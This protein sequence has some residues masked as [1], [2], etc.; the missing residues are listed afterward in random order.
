MDAIPFDRDKHM[1]AI[2]EWMQARGQR[3]TEG[4][5]AYFPA[6]GRIVEDVLVGFLYRTDAPAVGYMDSFVGNPAKPRRDIRRA[7]YLVVEALQV[8]AKEQ[9]V[10]LLCGAT[11]VPSILEACI[12]N[13]WH[14]KQCLATYVTKEL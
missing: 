14:M 3:L 6:T 4:G 2:H 7:M 8:A 13:G 5:E 1:E 9:G 10:S 11:R 12:A